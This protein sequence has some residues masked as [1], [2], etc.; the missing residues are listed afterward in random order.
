[1]SNCRKKKYSDCSFDCN[2]TINPFLDSN[3]PLA[4][5]FF[6]SYIGNSRKYLTVHEVIYM[7]AQISCLGMR[8][9]R[10]GGPVNYLEYASDPSYIFLETPPPPG[11]ELWIH[12]CLGI[13]NR[14]TY[15]IYERKVIFRNKIMLFW[16]ILYTG[17][18]S[19]DL[20]KNISF[21]HERQH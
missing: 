2:I 13:T 4:I 14:R 1:M 18:F 11:T 17:S 19:L 5:N 3:I 16:M 20:S 15:V 12:A 9:S 10:E 6:T 8:I 21:W 7:I